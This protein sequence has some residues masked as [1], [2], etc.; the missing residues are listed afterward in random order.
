MRPTARRPRSTPRIGSRGPEFRLGKTYRACSSPDRAFGSGP[1]GSRFDSCQAHQRCIRT[2]LRRGRQAGTGSQSG[3]SFPGACDRPPTTR[4][5]WSRPNGARD[6]WSAFS[7]TTRTPS[8]PG[9]ASL[10]TAGAGDSSPRLAA[11]TE[12]LPR[13]VRSFAARVAGMRRS[14]G[15]ERSVDRFPNQRGDRPAQSPRPLRGQVCLWS[16]QR[17]RQIMP[18]T[19]ERRT[20]ERRSGADRRRAERR[21]GTERRVGLTRSDAVDAKERRTA[22]RR[23]EYRRSLFNRRAAK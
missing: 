16:G 6:G 1:K 9:S 22:L 18:G 12:L 4:P 17:W 20:T 15:Y 13:P 21:S 5:L 10:L 2:A 23:K 3:R 11:D 8:R 7:R 19:M 14:S